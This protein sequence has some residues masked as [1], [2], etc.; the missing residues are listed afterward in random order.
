MLCGLLRPSERNARS[1]R[2]RHRLDR[3]IA[4]GGRSATWHRAS[5]STAILR[6]DENLE[7]YARAYGLGRTREKRKSE[8]TEIVG[9]GPYRDNARRAPFGRLAAAPGA[10]RRVDSRSAGRLSR[11]ADL[12]HRSGR[13]PQ[14]VGSAVPSDRGR[15]DVLRHDAL[16]GRSRTLRVAGV[17]FSARRLLASG[18]PESIR[19]LPV[20]NP[21]GMRRYSVATDDLMQTFRRVHSRCRRC[22]TRRFSDA[23]ST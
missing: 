12:R 19:S 7:F 5:R 3:S 6:V 13:A 4:Y 21:P 23:T 20:V 8:V 17:H 22:A 11:R 15:E 16:H 9:I 2:L 1:R 14:F 10:G 18:S